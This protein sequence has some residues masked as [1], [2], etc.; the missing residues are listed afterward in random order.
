MKEL[1]T[2]QEW[3]LLQRTP[4]FVFAMIATVDGVADKKESEAFIKF[5]L[6]KG[7]FK[8][9]LFNL[10]LP[11]EPK[12]YLDEELPKIDKTK[13]KDTLREIDATLD[14]K[15]N[16][17]ESKA[18]KHHLIAMATYIANASG[19]IFQHKISEEEN[20]AIYQF[21]KYIDID[22]AQLFKTTLVDEILKKVD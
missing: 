6:N 10:V 19:K 16:P 15:I 8:S 7:D 22:A 3:E 20:E 2:E 1:F 4:A 17:F 12:K 9:E 21:A 14:L 11:N 5:C 13:L 18:F